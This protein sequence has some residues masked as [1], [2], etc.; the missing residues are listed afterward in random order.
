MNLPDDISRSS[1]LKT[2]WVVVNA[3]IVALVA[4]VA[5]VVDVKAVFLRRAAVEALQ[6]HSYRCVAS[7]LYVYIHKNSDNRNITIQGGAKKRGHPILL[8][9]F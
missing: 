7:F 9:I 6:T 3:G 4:Q 5:F 8:Q 1:V 2:S